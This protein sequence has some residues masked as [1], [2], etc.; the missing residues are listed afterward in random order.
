MRSMAT[1]ILA[2]ALS[3]GCAPTGSPAAAPAAR[4]LI[5]AQD[6]E[7]THQTKNAI[8][9]YHQI[10]RYYPG[11]PEASR[12]ADRIRQ[13]QTAALKKSWARRAK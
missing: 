13:M 1:L 7:N 5:L 10:I 4:V 3:T 6:L 11:T 8:A 2:T 9:A 12:A